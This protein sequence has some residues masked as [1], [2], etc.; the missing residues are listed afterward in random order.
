M[1][2]I[3]PGKCCHKKAADMTLEEREQNA[4]YG[5]AAKANYSLSRPIVPVN[6]YPGKVC[7]KKT[8]DMSAYEHE[9]HLI[10]NRAKKAN[11][12]KNINQHEA[13]KIRNRALSAKMR[14]LNPEK[15][16]A[17]NTKSRTAMVNDPIRYAA[18]LLRAKARNDYGR[19]SMDDIYIKSLIRKRGDIPVELIPDE[20]ITVWRATLAVK[21]VVRELNNEELS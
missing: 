4:I 14:A 15:V 16:R 11:Y 19:E 10:Y 5:K 13:F 21:R 20:M 6:M 18:Y 7:S 9:Q 3:Y 17:A 1:A 12:R 2:S 8:T